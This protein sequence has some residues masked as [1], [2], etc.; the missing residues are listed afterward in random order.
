[1]ESILFIILIPAVVAIVIVVAIASHRATQKRRDDLAALAAEIGWSFNPEKDR[2]HDEEYAHFEI[3]RR[4]HSRSAYNTLAGLM[5][6]HGR[7][8]PAK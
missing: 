6:V 5:T 2:S 1:M 3:F 8:C 4:G 7:D